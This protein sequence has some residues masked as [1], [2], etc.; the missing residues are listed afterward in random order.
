MKTTRIAALALISTAAIGFNAYAGETSDFTPD[1]TQ[2]F[3]STLTRAQV[4][5]DAVQANLEI[6]N[7]GYNND[8][9]VYLIS[10]PAQSKDMSLTR[11]AVRADAIKARGM[12][13]V[14]ESNS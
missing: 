9:G 13:T 1:V 10:A 5:A 8:Q 12:I 14:V 11:E 6:T 7:R 3:V 4:Q 2:K